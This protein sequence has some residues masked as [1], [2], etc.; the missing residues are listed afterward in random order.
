M[1]GISSPGSPTR[2]ADF[3]V[4]ED[5]DKALLVFFGSDDQRMGGI[6]PE[7]TEIKRFQHYF[8]EGSE[9]QITSQ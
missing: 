5:C 7:D 9:T 4:R 1:Y 3:D 8:I 6:I 2:L